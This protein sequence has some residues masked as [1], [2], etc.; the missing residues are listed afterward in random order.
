MEKNKLKYR[1]RA[2][3]INRQKELN[4]LKIF[5]DEEPESVLFL[6]GP[7]SSGKTV[8]LYTFLDQ[9]EKEQELDVKFLNLRKT[10]TEFSDNYSYK[11][12]L[13][14]FFNVEDKEE[15]KR[16]LAAEINVGFFKISSEIEK[17]MREGKVDPFKVME[18]EF[19]EL[20][21][22][23][24]KP[25]LIIDELQALD[26]VYM[27]NGRDRR[28]I[29]ELFNFF[30]AM[31]KES[32]LAHIVIASSD[33]YFLNTVY[34]DSRLKKT[35]VFYKVDYLPKEDVMEWLLHLEKYSKIKDYTLTPEDAEKIWETVGGS[36]W[37]IQH[38]L[39]ELFENPIDEVLT[40]YKKK[41]RGIIAH[42]CQFDTKKKQVLGVVNE[43][44]IVSD[45]DFKNLP[46]EAAELKE[47]LRDMV[48]NN[49][50]Y[51]DPT[52]A[53]YYPQGKSFQWGIRLYFG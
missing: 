17:K 53:V 6:H 8:L 12:F 20:K 13:G 19:I 24:I 38:L 45:E 37:E 5:I 47:L 4:D 51:F 27:N 49:I 22:K 40:L 48:T 10:F 14:V 9:I 41:M 33:G 32:H 43:K 42:Y 25:I 35:S 23:G 21:E 50:L 16:K 46:I 39:T 15:K 18:K 31:T 44:G 7:K 3:F 1:K 34:N 30:V 2:A 26:K 29:I 11:D 52:E 36:M 28:L